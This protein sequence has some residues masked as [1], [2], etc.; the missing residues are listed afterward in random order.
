MFLEPLRECKNSE[1]ILTAK[2]YI[3]YSSSVHLNNG[4][5]LKIEYIFILN[6]F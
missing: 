5:S 2:I 3:F 6:D 4:F 1:N